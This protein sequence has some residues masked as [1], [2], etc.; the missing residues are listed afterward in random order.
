VKILAGHSSVVA[1]AVYSLDG[2]KI[3]SSSEDGTI[4]EWDAAIGQCLKTIEYKHPHNPDLSELNASV[5]AV[6]NNRLRT[7]GNI[8]YVPSEYG[9]GKEMK[10][11]NIPG[12]W[13]QGCSFKNLEKGSQWTDEGL[14]ILKQYHARI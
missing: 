6:A 2:K 1:L 7:D 14:K 11:I 4:K 12:L 13:I 10:L 8:I 3:L 9:K 5:I